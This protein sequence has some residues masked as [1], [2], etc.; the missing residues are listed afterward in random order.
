MID[1]LLLALLPSTITPHPV[2]PPLALVQDEQQEEE[3]DKAIREAGADVTKLIALGEKYTSEE[4]RKAA[5]AAYTRVLEVDAENEQAH[6]ALRHHRYDDRWFSTFSELSAY[7]RAEAKRMLEEHGLVRWRDEWVPQ[8]D[9]PFLRMGWE[10]AED[11]RWMRPGEAAK[12]AREEELRAEGWQQQDLTWVHPDDFDK[13]RE[14]LWKVGEEWVSKDEANTY[15]AEMDHWWEVPSESKYFI[16][17]TTCDHDTALWIGWYADL[18]YKD[19]ARIF[20]K[21]PDRPV[22]L[23][24]F[25]ELAQYNLFAAGDPSGTRQATEAGGHSSVHYAYFAETWFDLNQSPPSYRGTGVAFWDRSNPSLEPYGQHAVRHA[26]AH[27]Y[28]EAIDPSWNAVSGMIAGG[29][30]GFQAD[31]FWNEK[32]IPRWLRYGAASYVERFFVDETVQQGGNPL[33]ARE[34]ALENVRKSGG[35]GELDDVF[36]MVLDFN[37]PDGSAKRIHCAGLLVAFMLDGKCAP[38][39]EKHQAFKAALRAGESTDEAAQALQK[40]LVEN[41]KKIEEFAGL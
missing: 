9:L 21:K 32:R 3:H 37:D 17:L 5:R 11:G 38:V 28:A 4:N 24:V 13:W 14:G 7:K 39:I 40:A 33:W 20:G 6:K 10:H 25:K 23:V 26:A 30:G 1:A 16:S 35:L 22:E 2:A 15:H 12:L 19:L 8:L 27:G 18:T 34:W 29:A 41:R 31:N 36:G